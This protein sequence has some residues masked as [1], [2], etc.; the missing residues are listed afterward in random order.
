MI[1]TINIYVDNMN[2]C[3]Q[4]RFIYVGFFSFRIDWDMSFEVFWWK[5]LKCIIG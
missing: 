3:F 4:G 5:D 2:L 1:I